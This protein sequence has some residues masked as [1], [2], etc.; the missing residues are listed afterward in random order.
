V[1]KVDDGTQQLATSLNDGRDDVPSYTDEERAHLKTV[2]AD[3]TTAT[4]D[5]TPVG[6][7]TV[8]LFAVL[9]LWALALAT[10]IVTR[11]VPDAV[12][13]AREPTWRIIVRAAIPGAT[14]AA[15]AGLVITAIAAPVLDLSVA[16]TLGFLAVAL[17]AAGAFVALNQ[18]ATGIFGLPGRLASLAVLVLAAATGILS[19][20]PGPLYDL[21]GYLPTHGAVIAL[22]ATAT[23]G[24]GLVGGI[25]E[26]GVWLAIGALATIVVT[27]RRRYLSTK[28]LRH[29]ALRPATV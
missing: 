3:P 10:Y 2:A 4:V 6:T 7:L 13:T 18:A 23:G 15:L 16:G 26:L 14:A 25:V 24:P 28:Q 17:L 11:A 9:A 12:L 27:D 21:A 29:S 1:V 5:S 20:L 22:R 19:T 8:T